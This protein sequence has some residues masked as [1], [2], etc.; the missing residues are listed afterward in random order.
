MT[1]RLPF[2]AYI[3]RFAGEDWVQLCHGQTRGQALARFVRTCPL[4]MEYC[5]YED[6]RLT[7]LPGCDDKPLTQDNAKAAGFE[8]T[9][10]DGGP[11]P[12][13]WE[14]ENLC[15]CEVCKAGA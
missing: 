11:L 3:A 10:E 6:V 9:E 5:N 14:W 7:R 2:L 1:T 12:E 13:W 8:F 15:D 4:A